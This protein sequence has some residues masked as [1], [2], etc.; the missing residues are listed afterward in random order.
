VT[1]SR[2]RLALL[3]V[4]S[5]S[6]TPATA[7]A[8]PL[9]SSVPS[10]SCATQVLERPFLR[11]LDPARYTLVPDGTLERGA[12]GWA[13][14]RATV[15]KGNEPY[16]VHARGETRSLR[17][18]PGSSAITPPMCVGVLHPTLRLFARRTGG[19][20]L[21]G[22]RVDVLFE[23]AGGRVRSLPIG[24]ALGGSRWQ[25][26]L[27]MPV[28]ANL[29]PLLPGQNTAVAFRFSPTGWGTWQID[30][31]YVDPHRRG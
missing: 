10:S 4:I 17:L 25:P 18:P 13:L 20:F 6:L 29:L 1:I 30:D 28:V 22:L 23:D 27:P 3:V 15:V 12:A 31:V 9:V 8:G 5:M 2:R 21:S 11:W 14:W 26:T 19:S 16:Y 24:L 7:Q